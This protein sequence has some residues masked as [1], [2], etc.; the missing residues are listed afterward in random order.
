MS[1]TPQ[2]SQYFQQVAGS[3]D[4]IS[5]GYFTEAVRNTAIAKAY[6]RPEMAVADIGAGTGFLSAGLA[7]L[8]KRV[9]VVDG[10]AAMLEVARQNLRD[11]ANIEFHE[12][13]M[14]K[15]PMRRVMANN[16]GG[17]IG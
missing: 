11:F 7:P 5:A 6:L 15:P 17:T 8:V 1:M 16:I 2:S 14:N 4:K 9:Y 10:S 13:G 12:A 3:W